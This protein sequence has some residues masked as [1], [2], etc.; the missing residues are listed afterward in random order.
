MV[1]NSLNFLC[2]FIVVFGG[3]YAP[4]IRNNSKNQNTGLFIASYFFYGFADWK[5]I[6]LLLVATVTFYKIG[7]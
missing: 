6:P 1:V 4:T 2:F 5:M 7:I 3:Y